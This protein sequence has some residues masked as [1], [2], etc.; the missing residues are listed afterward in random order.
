[1]R[2]GAAEVVTFP[3]L[4][5]DS[6][7]LQKLL[8]AGGSAFPPSALKVPTT[9][10]TAVPVRTVMPSISSEMATAC[11]HVQECTSMAGL[12]VECARVCPA[13][14]T[15]ARDERMPTLDISVTEGAKTTEIKLQECV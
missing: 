8:S 5:S 3:K 11:A 4:G 7:C 1:M 13:Q 6:D 15:L 12:R 2:R 9:T 10:T 14:V